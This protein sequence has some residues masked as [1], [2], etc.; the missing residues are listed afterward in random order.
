MGDAEMSEHDFSLYV[1]I[2]IYT[3]I[4][5]HYVHAKNKKGGGEEQ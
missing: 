3:Y 5:G 2:Y 1:N 4:Y